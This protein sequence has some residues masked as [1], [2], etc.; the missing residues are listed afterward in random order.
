VTYSQAA[1]S[2]PDKLKS[3]KTTVTLSQ[4]NF[5]FLSQINTSVDG[6]W[7]KIDDFQYGVLKITLLTQNP[8]AIAAQNQLGQ[9][10]QNTKQDHLPSPITGMLREV[11]PY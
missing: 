4:A 10:L 7:A 11:T 6:D 2:S 8:R 5:K 9:P 1:F 3:L